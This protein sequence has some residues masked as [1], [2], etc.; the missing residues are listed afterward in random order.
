MPLDAG[1]QHSRQTH[2]DWQ[3]PLLE[4]SPSHSSSPNMTPHLM[5]SYVL[6]SSAG[7]SLGAGSYPSL[8]HAQPRTQPALEQAYTTIKILRE[9]LEGARTQLL[10]AHA[11]TPGSGTGYRG[12]DPEAA[13]LREEV[14]RLRS[15]LDDSCS[16]LKQQASAMQ[17]AVSGA[18]SQ[19]RVESDVLREDIRKLTEQVWYC[20]P[21]RFSLHCSV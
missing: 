2:S 6:A 10:D 13:V 20:T 9:E 5:A 19:H 7:N 8:N 14:T 11:K 12:A 4:R 18:S 17:T 3:T 16:Q 15:Q 1:E 21:P